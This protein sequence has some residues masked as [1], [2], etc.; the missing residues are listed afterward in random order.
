MTTATADGAPPAL[1]FDR[2]GQLE[3]PDS[4]WTRDDDGRPMILPDPEWTPGQ[5]QHWLERPGTKDGRRHYTRVT[6][7]AE[8]LLDGT[9]L[10]RWKMRRVALG[11]GRRPDY[12]V[13]AAALTA[14][15]RDREALNDLAEKALEAAGPNAADI[16]T[17][18]HG[19]SERIDRGEPVGFVPEPYRADLDA[20]REKVQQHLTWK[21]REERMVCDALETA[22]TPDGIA[23]V[24][25]PDPDGVADLLR[26]VDLKTGNVQTTAG[27]FSCQ[28]GIYANSALYDPQTGKRTWPAD[29]DKRWGVVLHMPAG[30]GT[31]ELR[32]LNLEHGWLGAQLAGPVR[33][34]RTVNYADLMRPLVPVER[35][36]AD[37]MCRGV[38]RDGEPCGYKAKNDGLCTRHQG[39][40]PDAVIPV[41]VQ[42]VASEL[43]TALENVP[44]P[45]RE[46][47]APTP[48]TEQGKADAILERDEQLAQPATVP[49]LEGLDGGSGYLE[50]AD[51]LT[52]VLEQVAP[53]SLAAARAAEQQMRCERS[54][55]L[56]DQCACP[57]H[58]PD[59]ATTGDDGVVPDEGPRELPREQQGN[60]RPHTSM[61]TPEDAA[62][63]AAKAELALMDQVR[64]C[65]TT[66]EL[67]VLWDATGAA[68]TP[69]VKSYAKRHRELLPE[70]GQKERAGAA[71]LAAIHAAASQGELRRLFEDPRNAE[72]I[73][74]EH[75]A[76]ARAR[77]ADLPPF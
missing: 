27:K 35:V 61:P 38:K 63:A 49:A 75:K 36:V 13:A 58:R 56:V 48:D 71:L 2:P 39:Q 50:N 18:L 20:Y 10:G 45:L 21:H 5:L 6:T 43:T 32:W 12:V 64:A 70:L 3:R 46:P 15:D 9:M 31:A 66:G 59:L 28:L 23:Y 67:Q 57:V 51:S 68:W 47:A 55:L 40:D 11:M 52:D 37:G 65:R 42:Q 44:E 22:G 29:L 19:F 53:E 26:I 4:D 1:T 73:G 25:E 17:A 76:A 77:A 72:L 7:F 41:R 74:D 54:G 16:G 60:P 24:D 8:A 34:W 69:T 33:R 62:D 14:E 30:V